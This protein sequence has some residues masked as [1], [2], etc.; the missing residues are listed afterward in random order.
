VWGRGNKDQHEAFHGYAVCI[1]LIL[2]STLQ[3]YPW[4]IAVLVGYTLF[5]I[6]VRLLM[7]GQGKLVT[8][9]NVLL[10]ECPAK[11]YRHSDFDMRYW[12]GYPAL[13]YVSKVK[14]K[15]TGGICKHRGKPDTFRLL[16]SGTASNIL[17]GGGRLCMFSIERK[18]SKPNIRVW[19]IG[20]ILSSETQ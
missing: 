2:G 13:N 9:N 15:L 14:S 1:S 5:G 11:V 16:M 7:D 10:F 12:T 8:G 6:L 3:S 17:L 19:V 4:Y 18:V 20:I